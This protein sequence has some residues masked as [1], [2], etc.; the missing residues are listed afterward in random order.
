M[1]VLRF[2]GLS[3][4]ELTEISEVKKLRQLLQRKFYFKVKLRIRLSVLRLIHVA[5]F[6]RNESA[7]C[8][9]A[10]LQLARMVFV[11]SSS[12]KPGFSN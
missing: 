9:C 4:E 2:A 7:N 10:Q 12:E 3:S 5:Y 6:E 1:V 8:Y 11:H